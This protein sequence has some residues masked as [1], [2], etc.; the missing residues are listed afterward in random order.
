MSAAATMDNAYRSN[1]YD[2]LLN[3]IDALKLIIYSSQ[4]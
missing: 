1:K 4:T 2:V 3:T